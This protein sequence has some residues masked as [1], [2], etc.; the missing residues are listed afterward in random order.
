MSI[1]NKNL[2]ELTW[3][4]FEEIKS[5]N[6]KIEW[7]LWTWMMTLEQMIKSNKMIDI[8]KLSACNNSLNFFIVWEIIYLIIFKQVPFWMKLESTEFADLMHFMLKK[9]I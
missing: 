6:I 8:E 5:K 4:F 3:N 7:Y 2:E 1:N 9:M